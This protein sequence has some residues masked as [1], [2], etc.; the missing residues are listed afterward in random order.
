[1]IVVTLVGQ[2]IAD[3]EELAECEQRCDA[4]GPLRHDELMRDLKTGPVALA[5]S[6]VRLPDQTDGEATFSVHESKDPADR[7]QSFLLIVWRL[8]CREA[9]S[10]IVSRFHT[11]NIGVALREPEDSSRGSSIWSDFSKAAIPP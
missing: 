2:E 3:T 9:T 10:R 5:V 4:L 11:R 6:A 1:M 7:D 8:L